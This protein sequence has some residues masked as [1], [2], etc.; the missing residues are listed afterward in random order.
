MGGIYYIL[1]LIGML[2]NR[3]LRK[4]SSLIRSNN[5]N[6]IKRAIQKLPPFA[7]VVCIIFLVYMNITGVRFAIA[8][9]AGSTIWATDL[10]ITGP[11]ALSIFF[12][13]LMLFYRRAKQ[14]TTL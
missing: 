9:G 13:I 1:L 11:F 2:V 5:T 10:G 3:L 14:R 4:I 12:V 6:K 8:H 7:F